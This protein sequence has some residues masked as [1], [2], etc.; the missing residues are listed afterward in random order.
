MVQC[1]AR[2]SFGAVLR[3]MVGEIA[4]VFFLFCVNGYHRIPG[5][6]KFRSQAVYPPKLL[7]PVR[8]RLPHLFRFF[9]FLTAVPHFPQN[10]RHHRMTYVYM[11]FLMEDMEKEAAPPCVVYDGQS[12]RGACPLRA[13]LLARLQFLEQV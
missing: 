7:I 8:I 2:S 4:Y 5:C 3:P 10:L 11:V 1:T 13:S 12:T 9:V 6:Q